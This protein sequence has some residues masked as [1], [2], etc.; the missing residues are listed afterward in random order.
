MERRK[1]SEFVR[2]DALEEELIAKVEK[3]E[4]KEDTSLISEEVLHFG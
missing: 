2:F 4:L 1:T 3:Q